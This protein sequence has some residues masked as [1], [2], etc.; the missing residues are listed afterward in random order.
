MRG[1]AVC[2]GQS[3]Q[4]RIT[5]DATPAL[6]AAEGTIG[7]QRE[8]VPET[9]ADNPA[10]HARVVPQAQ[11]DLHR[12]DLGDAP[13]FL[14]LS[15]GNV[16]QPDGVDQTAPRQRVQGTDARGQRYARIGA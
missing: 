4:N 13:G 2:C 8:A 12:G 14:D 5:F 11:L 3:G 1:R 9:V 15:D 7:E 6:R 10:Q 16:T